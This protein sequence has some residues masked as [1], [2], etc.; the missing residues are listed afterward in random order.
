M[1]VGGVEAAINVTAAGYEASLG[2]SVDWSLYV[3][4]Y[5]AAHSY[6][7]IVWDTGVAI[8]RDLGSRVDD[9]YMQAEIQ[10]QNGILPPY[11]SPWLIIQI[12]D[13]DSRPPVDVKVVP[14]CIVPQF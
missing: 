9:Q 4:G 6:T 3:D 5:D 11:C 8:F 12:N 10:Q 7:I 14:E 13:L 1:Q 2:G